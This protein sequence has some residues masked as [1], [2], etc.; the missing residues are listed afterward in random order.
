MPLHIHFVGIKGTGMSALSQITPMIIDACITGSDVPQ[1]FFTDAVLEKAGITVLDFDPENVT[2]ADLVVTSAA[3]DNSHPEIARAIA[4]K[5][6]VLTY[7]QFLGQL[8]AKKKGVC[9]AGTHGK[10]TTTAMAGKI[11]LDAGLDPSIVV[12]SDVPCIGGN[13]HA[14]QGELFLAESCEYRRHFLNYAPEHLVITNMELDHPDYFKDLDDVISA[15]SELAWKLPAS[16][17]LIIWHEDLNR[18]RIKTK[19]PVTTFGFSPE[20]DVRAVNIV[21][22]DAGST[23]DVMLGDQKLGNLHLT[24]SGKHNILDALAAIALTIKLNIPVSVI[25]E[26]L[27]NFNGTKRRFE[28]LGTKHGAVIVDDYAHHPT[29]IQTT[30]NGARLSYPNRRIRAVFQ[31]HT[32]SRTEK[33]L[34][35]FSQAF[36]DADEVVIA[37]IFSS[38]REKKAGTHSV[39]SAKLAA[40]MQETGI[41]TRY[42][43]TLEE[44]SSYLD[45]TLEKND[46]VITLGAGDVYK[47]GQNLVC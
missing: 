22:D 18:S 30:L 24:V 33:L 2:C 10:T 47:V 19:A 1:R 21:F 20:A 45:Q 28:R 44:I 42:F 32:F 15:F 26:A 37:E 39:S 29:E 25:L 38:A 6:P 36:H 46:L 31:P 23:F 35:E 3:Y 8:M 14:G 17:N 12:G 34:Y 27:S 7:A 16:G 13:S 4:L 11:L 5:I 40:L 43:S 41:T 9:V